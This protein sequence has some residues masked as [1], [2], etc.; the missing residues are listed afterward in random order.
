MCEITRWCG[1]ATSSFNFN[2]DKCTKVTLVYHSCILYLV[3]LSIYICFSWS[4]YI[5]MGCNLHFMLT[6][7][8]DCTFCFKEFGPLKKETVC[9]QLCLWQKLT[10]TT[11]KCLSVAGSVHYRYYKIPVML[12]MTIILYDF[13]PGIRLGVIHNGPPEEVPVLSEITVTLLNMED[14]ELTPFL[15][16]FILSKRLTEE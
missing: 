9:V 4:L 11:G 16:K 13:S 5:N 6:V 3:R 8:S 7:L 14:T 1:G 12:L 15:K 2:S 10:A